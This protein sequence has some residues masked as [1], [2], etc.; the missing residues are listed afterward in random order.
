MRYKLLVI[1]MLVVGFLAINLGIDKNFVGPYGHEIAIAGAGDPCP[2][3]SGGNP[4]CMQGC[5]S[6]W[7]TVDG[8]RVALCAELGDWPPDPCKCAWDAIEKKNVKCGECPLICD[9]GSADCFYDLQ[10]GCCTGDRHIA[11][12]DP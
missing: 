2:C 12:E 10:Q 3:T 11:C 7:T 4:W 9:H 8:C 5:G 6:C 1:A